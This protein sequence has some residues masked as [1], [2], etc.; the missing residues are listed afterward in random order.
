[1]HTNFKTAHNFSA[2]GKPPSLPDNALLPLL[3]LQLALFLAGLV[4]IIRKPLPLSM[5][6]KWMP[7]LLVNTIGPLIY[8]AVGSRSLDKKAAL[9]QELEEI[10]F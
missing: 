6:W 8:F 4:S 3:L 5:K 2:M 9:L 10:D 7:L 1:M